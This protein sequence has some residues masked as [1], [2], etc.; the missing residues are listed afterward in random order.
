M[1]FRDKIIPLERVAVWRG[2]VRAAGK[3]L[4]V[5]NGCFDILHAGHVTYLAAARALG[6]VLLVGL[7]S[8][9][10]VRQLKGAG[11]PVNPERDRATVLA[12]LAAVDGVC[13]FEEVDALRLLAEVKPDIYAK[14]GD[15]TIDTINQPERRLVEAAGGR[16]VILPGVPGRST[17]GVLEKIAKG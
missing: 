5:T 2:Q 8:D 7:N 10:S 12:A 9:A 14:G 3:R 11:R 16:V 13:L 6:D 4:V 17:T 1:D 15:Y